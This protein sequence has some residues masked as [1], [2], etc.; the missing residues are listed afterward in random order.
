MNKTSYRLLIPALVVA[1]ALTALALVTSSR[2]TA[3]GE[4]HY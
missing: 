4:T 2:V 3:Q 1:V